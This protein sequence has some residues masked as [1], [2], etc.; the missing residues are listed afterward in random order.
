MTGTYAA[1]NPGLERP[2]FAY[3]DQWVP[4]R[5]EYPE[6]PLQHFLTASAKAYPNREA[7]IFYGARLTYRVLT[8]FFERMQL[9]IAR[10]GD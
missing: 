3:Y 1:T 10:P 4:K 8:V 7:I 6:A 9:R 2:W 5:L